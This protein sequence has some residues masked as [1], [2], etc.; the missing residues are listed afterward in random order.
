MQVD[1]EWLSGKGGYGGT[2][3]GISL[4]SGDAGYLPPIFTSFQGSKQQLPQALNA[5]TQRLKNGV[6]QVQS[7]HRPIEKTESGWKGGSIKKALWLKF[8]ENQCF[9]ES[10]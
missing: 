4:L 2:V 7:S 8:V 10:G 9:Y 1:T 6:K 3:V 5:D